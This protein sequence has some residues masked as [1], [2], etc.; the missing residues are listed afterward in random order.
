MMDV[1]MMHSFGVFDREQWALLIARAAHA[2]NISHR[3]TF[4]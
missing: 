3:T 1:G 4:Q 2:K